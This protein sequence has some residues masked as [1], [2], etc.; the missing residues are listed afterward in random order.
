MYS[1]PVEI[2]VPTFSVIND[3][4]LFFGIDFRVPSEVAIT[5]SPV[6]ESVE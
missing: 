1:Y 6:E 5:T 3:E 2:M 4:I